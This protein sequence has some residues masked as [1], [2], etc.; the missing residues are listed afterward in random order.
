[1][2]EIVIHNIN[3]NLDMNFWARKADTMAFQPFSQNETAALPAVDD[4]AREA[5]YTTTE[6]VAIIALCSAA[7]FMLMIVVI[8]FVNEKNSKQINKAMMV[9]TRPTFITID[10]KYCLMRRCF[11]S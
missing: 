4:D 11:F 9:R 7:V 6:A 1:M 8:F 3:T 5:G 2:D 10:P